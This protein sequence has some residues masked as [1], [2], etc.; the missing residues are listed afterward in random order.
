MSYAELYPTLIQK[1][2][3]QTMTPPSIPKELPL[4]YKSDH[5]CAFH[6]GALG[7]DIENCLALKAEVK[8]LMQSGML[9]FEDSG[10]N[11]QANPLPKHSG[12]TVNMVEGCSWK[13]PCL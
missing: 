13:V 3:V 9:S 6:K 1:N 2:L 12:V 7:H 8:R 11:V 10:P 4:W 5:H